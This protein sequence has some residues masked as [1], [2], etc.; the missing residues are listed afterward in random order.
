MRQTIEGVSHKVTLNGSPVV[1]VLWADPETGECELYVHCREGQR[2]PDTD[3]PHGYQTIPVK[4]KVV[5]EQ[6]TAPY[7]PPTEN[8]WPY[9]MYGASGCM[10][11]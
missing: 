6:V 4:G 7:V 1:D 11:C 8:Q 2:I 10:P 3:N 9:D 5:V